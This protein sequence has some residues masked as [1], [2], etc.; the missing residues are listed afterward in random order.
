MRSLRAV[1]ATCH[2]QL[3]KNVH[4]CTTMVYVKLMSPATMNRTLSLHVQWPVLH[5]NKRTF[6]C[7]RPSVDVTDSPAEQIVMIDKS[8]RSFFTFC[9]CC[10]ATLH[11][12][13][14]N[15]SIVKQYVLHTMSVCVCVSV[16]VLA[17]T[18]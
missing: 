2:C 17:L 3:Y 8:L 16:S 14:R 11:E 13:R 9:K 18:L 1:T 5:R 6:V 12:N 4:C 15:Q 10:R 7:S